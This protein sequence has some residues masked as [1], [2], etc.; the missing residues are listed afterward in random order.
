MAQQGQQGVVPP[1]VIHHGTGP[2]GYLTIHQFDRSQN[3][4]E[5]I[6]AIQVNA[7]LSSLS[8]AATLQYAKLM[9]SPEMRVGANGTTDM[10]GLIAYLQTQVAGNATLRNA[11]RRKIQTMKI[12]PM[13]DLA[14]LK[15]E[16][17]RLFGTGQI[18]EQAERV[19]YLIG[20]LSSD[21]Y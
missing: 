15:R 2:A 18:A 19:N 17:N 6:N 1:A 16:V 11:A 3:S 10:A 21:K 7:V 5:W 9:V 8:E 20:M 13:Q 4:E 14:K 12:S